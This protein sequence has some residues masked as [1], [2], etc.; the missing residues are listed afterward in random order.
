MVLLFKK[1]KIEKMLKKL[2]EDFDLYK[3]AE[4]DAQ[5]LKKIAIKNCIAN[6]ES[7]KDQLVYKYASNIAFLCSNAMTRMARCRE[8]LKEGDLN[9]AKKHSDI[10]SAQ[11]DCAM[12]KNSELIAMCKDYM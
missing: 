11:I 8:S 4:K 9:L 10:A 1:K 7:E 2:N 5:I 12:S 6:P 3:K